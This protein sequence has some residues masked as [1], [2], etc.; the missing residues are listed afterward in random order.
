MYSKFEVLLSMRL[1]I[2]KVH[3]GAVLREHVFTPNGLPV[4]SAG[5]RLT[6]AH[7]GLLLRHQVEYVD[8]VPY[9]TD[10]AVSRQAPSPTP[11]REVYD[12]A[13]GRMKSLFDEAFRYGVLRT[14][15]IDGTFDPFVV[16]IRKE[17]DVVGLLLTLDS[18][19]DY[20]YEHCVQ[21]GMLSYYI[22][23]WLNYSEPE[24]YAVGKAGFLHDI[25]KSK[26]HKTILLK[27]SR[28]TDDEYAEIK[29]HTVHGYDIILKSLNDREAAYAALQHHE[30]ASGKGYPFGITYEWVHPYSKIVAVA[31][32]YSAMIS[33]RVYQEKQDLFVVLKELHELSYSELDPHIVQTFIRRMIPSFIGRQAALTDGRVGEIVLGHVA[34]LFKPLVRIGDEFVDLARADAEIERILS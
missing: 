14:E 11:L 6:T 24:A 23:K 18:K 19:D 9:S 29:Q 20:T 1:H 30:R 32:V 8:V 26:I 27:P 22:A 15:Q 3:T 17:T 2:T 12:Q 21:V 10:D 34:E 25:G 16:S 33:S 5:I 31:D 4:L 7:I 28:L 13:V